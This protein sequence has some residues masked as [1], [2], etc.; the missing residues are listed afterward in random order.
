[1][2]LKIILFLLF[3]QAP[4]PIDPWQGIQNATEDGAACPQPEE[5]FL[6]P[7]SEDCL[8][9]NIYTTKVNVLG[10]SLRIHFDLIAL[11]KRVVSICTHPN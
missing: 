10:I 6:V 11:Q 2:H 9:L 5:N 7:T 3:L 8:F 4:V 1:V